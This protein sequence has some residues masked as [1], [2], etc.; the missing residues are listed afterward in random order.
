MEFE[1]TTESTANYIDDGLVNL[2]ISNGANSCRLNGFYKC[3]TEVPTEGVLHIVKNW[4]FTSNGKCLAQYAWDMTNL[5]KYSRVL[6]NNVWEPWEPV[7]S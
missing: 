5:L 7:L 6:I 3:F 2:P 4:E 1:I